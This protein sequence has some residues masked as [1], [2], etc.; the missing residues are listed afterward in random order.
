MV[1]IAEAKAAYDGIKAAFEMTKGVA[2]L[3]SEAEINAAVLDIQRQLLEAQAAAL[4]D[5]ERMTVLLAEVEDM[6]R[7]LAAGD[8][9]AQ[10]KSRYRLTR[11]PMGAFTYD[12]IPEEA[13]G[14][15]AHRLC[16]TC[17]ENGFKSILHTR[18]KHSQGEI[19][20]CKRC[21]S[22]LVLAPFM[23]RATARRTNRNPYT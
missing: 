22:E 18:A 21:E 12:L 3:K 9:W 4:A 23:H 5:R 6:K 2:A 1:G 15:E 11:S 14:E 8:D 17:F 16:T 10:Q 19:V 20:V 13:N 7:R